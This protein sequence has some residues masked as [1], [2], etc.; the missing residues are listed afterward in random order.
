MLNVNDCWMKSYCKKYQNN[1]CEED[2]DFCIK[3]FKLEKLYDYSLLSPS[4]REHQLLKIDSDGT[5]REAFIELKRIETDIENWVDSG[6]NLYLYSSICGN[7]KTSWS[8]RLIQSYLEKIWIKSDLVCRALFV[9]VPSFLIALKDNISRVNDYAEYIKSNII[10]A[11]L[12]V[13][14]DIAIKTA[15]TYEMEN[16]LSIINTRL[17]KNMSNI[18]TSN[19]IGEAL[20]VSLGERLYSRIINLSQVIEFQGQDK[21]G[22]IQ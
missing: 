20:K 5:D 4:Q 7:G 16:L 17:M 12:V 11:N 14:D 9:N 6:K 3:L 10:D 2:S 22:L 19:L 18:Y 1:K 8:I 13:W 15:T 21:R